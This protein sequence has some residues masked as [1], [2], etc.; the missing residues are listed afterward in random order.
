VVSP[1]HNTPDSAA[2]RVPAQ[3]ASAGTTA[4]A[5]A[6]GNDGYPSA[7]PE[8][9]AAVQQLGATSAQR[10]RTLAAGMSPEELKSL[11]EEL[12]AYL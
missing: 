9:Y 11:V 4:A 8:A 7:Q 12:R 2:E 5:S 10:A 1:A 3:S 6:V